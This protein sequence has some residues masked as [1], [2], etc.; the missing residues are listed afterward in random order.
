MHIVFQFNVIIKNIGILY[1][2][3]LFYKCF[4]FTN[5]GM[6]ITFESKSK[7]QIPFVTNNDVSIGV[8]VI[9]IEKKR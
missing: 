1:W 9:N 6:Q 3:T 8:Y 7:K 5:F 4:P 2:A